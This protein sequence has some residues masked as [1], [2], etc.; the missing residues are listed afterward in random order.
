MKK[1][2]AVI[3]AVALSSVCLMASCG[4]KDDSQNSSPSSAAKLVFVGDLQELY[5]GEKGYP[6]AVLVAKTD[7]IQS[8]EDWVKMF[9]QSVDE[10]AEWLKTAEAQ[11]IVD[12]VSAH[13]TEGMTPSFN[14][15][16]LSSTV[17]S[18]CGIRFEAAAEYKT[19]VNEF[20]NKLIAVNAGAAAVVSDA[21]YYTPSSAPGNPDDG[22]ASGYPVPSSAQI[23]MPDGATALSLAK[24][25]HE[26]MAEPDVA[27]Y[28][29]VNAST[30]QTYVT[31]E[32]PKADLCILPLN[33]ASKLLCTGET[34]RMLGTVTHGNLYMLSTDTATQYTTENLSSLV[35]KTVG[36]VQLPNVPGLTFKIILDQHEIP[37]QELTND[38]PPAADKVNL[39]AMDPATVNP[40]AGLDCY[41]VPE[42]VASAKAGK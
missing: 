40:A 3:L 32:K 5:G 31:G 24:L 12:A 8:Y 21:F 4:G 30:I 1:K 29:V 6:Q 34:Y 14:V 18:H 11:T 2:L 19:E 39:K 9:L 13:L 37:W 17:I 23:Y 22:I 35:G 27:E 15:K 38:V 33:L 28:H 26:D 16:N 41:V 36:V 7:F 42:P 25:M 20:L 10:G